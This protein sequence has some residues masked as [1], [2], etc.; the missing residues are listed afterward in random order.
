M[1]GPP[2]SV[3]E[4]EVRALYRGHQIELLERDDALADFPKFAQRGVT[5]LGEAIYRCIKS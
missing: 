5:R 1:P 3:L 2:H 4:A